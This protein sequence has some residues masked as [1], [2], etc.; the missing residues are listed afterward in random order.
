MAK[1]TISDLRPACSDLFADSES[2]LQYLTEQEMENLGI[3][4]GW[5]FSFSFS[6]S[7]SFK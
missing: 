3:K 2:F 7:L 6:I 5:S 1:I 4:G